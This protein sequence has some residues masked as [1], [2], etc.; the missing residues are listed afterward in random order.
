MAAASCVPRY[1]GRIGSTGPAATGW[2]KETAATAAVDASLLLLPPF[3]GALPAFLL[4]LAAL[5][6]DA[7]EL[8]ADSTLMVTQSPL[9][10]AGRLRT[11]S[12]SGWRR[13]SSTRTPLPSRWMLRL[14]ALGAAAWLRRWPWRRSC[15]PRREPEVLATRCSCWR[16]GQAQTKSRK[17]LEERRHEQ[18]PR[19]P[20]VRA[21]PFPRDSHQ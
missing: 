12:T 4:P 2:E 8:E 20:P 10:L 9:G 14:S 3:P 17:H 19:R 7:A 1:V 5:G 13:D 21:S 11:T 6:L 18:E 15:C 16:Q